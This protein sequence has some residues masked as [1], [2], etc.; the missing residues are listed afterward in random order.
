MAVTSI[1]KDGIN[2][3]ARYAKMS[4]A[5]SGTSRIVVWGVSSTR[6]TSTDGTNWAATLGTTTSVSATDPF[7]PVTKNG[8]MICFTGTSFGV[9][10]WSYEGNYFYQTTGTPGDA[11]ANVYCYEQ[12]A[13]GDIVWTSFYSGTRN[14]I[15]REYA[16]YSGNAGSSPFSAAIYGIANNGAAGASCV[17]VACFGG[18]GNIAYSTN[19]GITWTTV[20]NGTGTVRVNWGVDKFLAWNT[21]S[22]GVGSTYYTSTNGSSWTSRT[23]PVAPQAK[24]SVRF[25]NGLWFL[26]SSSGALYTSSDGIT[27]TS[28]VSG[29][30][31]SAIHGF[32]YAAGFYVACGSSGYLATSP[33]GITWTARSSG[34]ANDLYV[35]GGF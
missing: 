29:A 19:D 28:R 24:S 27:W 9:W 15:V 2:N 11:N 7:Y 21:G 34:T 18:V 6:I 32:G 22:S 5:F 12:T 10:N 3:Y 30:G 25:V 16:V 17:W 31:S 26:G 1:A 23:F 20:T 14:H 13:T 33:D 35:V 4:A 8:R